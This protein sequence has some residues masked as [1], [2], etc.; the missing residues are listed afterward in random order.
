MYLRG[1]SLPG[2]M[3]NLLRMV[4]SYLAAD[5]TRLARRSVWHE[6]L[7][8]G[9]RIGLFCMLMPFALVPA[10]LSL[11]FF[12]NYLGL[13]SHSL[14]VDR[15]SV[16]PVI[17]QLRTTWDL[18]PE[19]FLAALLTGGLNAHVTHHV[20]PSL[21]R[22][23]QKWG[24]RVLREEGGSEYR[25]VQSLMGIW[26]LFRFRHCSTS[27]I[28][29]I[30]AI[31]A[32][33]VMTGFTAH[34]GTDGVEL[35]PQTYKW[36]RRHAARVDDHSK[37]A[38]NPAKRHA[39]S[40]RMQQGAKLAAKRSLRLFG[41]AFVSSSR[42]YSNATEGRSRMPVDKRVGER[43][44]QQTDFTSSERRLGDRRVHSARAVA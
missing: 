1:H 31:G 12:G 25:C 44:M 28:A 40:G 39:M 13:L 17:R 42:A 26:T 21:P 9:V 7:G 6:W 10:I 14:P 41:V 4:L 43:R 33:E 29:T 3:W 22:G 35:E 37:L 5:F 27:E 38:S 23:A 8:M 36:M 24:A 15:R 34:R 18:Y 2:D 20:Y 19:S 32:G 16:D 30:E 11:L